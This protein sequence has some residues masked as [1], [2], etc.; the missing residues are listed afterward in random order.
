MERS[1]ED[2]VI[3]EA[4]NIP[5]FQLW[6]D[7]KFSGESYFCD[8]YRHRSS[9]NRARKRLEA[10]ARQHASEDLVDSFWII[11]MTLAEHYRWVQKENAYRER[12]WEEI[13]RHKAYINEVMPQ[14]IEFLKNAIKTPGVNV[15]KVSDKD[16]QLH[17]TSLSVEFLK[18]F[19]CRTKHDLHVSIS[20]NNEWTA[21]RLTSSSLWMRSG[22]KD[23]IRKQEITEQHSQRIQEFFNKTIEKYFYGD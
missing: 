16:E 17:I 5:C 3:K 14:F 20:F 18:R 19:R 2:K 15:F 13:D 6:G 7:D 11:P 1:E 22:T 21:A 9:A 4:E 23:E 12:T 8:V 10:R